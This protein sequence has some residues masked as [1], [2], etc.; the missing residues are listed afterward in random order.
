MHKNYFTL[1]ALA[2][3]FSSRLVDT[4]FLE[5]YSHQPDELI[6]SFLPEGA[7]A[8]PINIR[9]ITNVQRGCMFIAPYSNPPKRNVAHFFSSLQGCVISGVEMSAGDRIV[10]VRCD[11][12]ELKTIALAM[13]GKSGGNALLLNDQ[14]LIEESFKSPKQL[15]GTVFNDTAQPWRSFIESKD[16][17][18][19]TLHAFAGTIKAALSKAL[20]VLGGELADE[21]FFRAG[22]DS[23]TEAGMISDEQLETLFVMLQDILGEC[24]HHVHPQV[25]SH[26]KKIFFALIKMKHAGE[27]RTIPCESVSDGVRR[28]F[29]GSAK[30]EHVVDESGHV[31]ATLDRAIERTE[32]ALAGVNEDLDRDDEQELRKMGELLS[33]HAH[34]MAMGIPS[35]TLEGVDIALDK[36]LNA[37]QNAALYFERA[38]K[39]KAAV[40]QSQER[41]VK[42]KARLAQFQRMKT[43]LANAETP[44]QRKKLIEMSSKTFDAAERSDPAT[45]PKYPYRHFQLNDDCEVFVGKNAKQNDELTFRF[46]KQNDLWFHARGVEGSHTVLRWS[47][48]TDPPKEYI[49]RAAAI[50]AFYSK[51]KNSKYVPVAYTQRKYIHKPR[52]AKPGSV[53]VTREEV[54]MVEP[55]IPENTSED[56]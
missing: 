1:A 9:F 22:I 51:A 27:V 17:L 46:A 25:L 47:R 30:Q 36:K 32:R 54:V 21:I 23:K 37:I 16:H 29:A 41:L 33:A 53:A 34:E 56:I 55:R 45:P 38:K 12:G 5:A 11:T 15:T 10:Y 20:P 50:A 8:E 40:V 14:S 13:F 43:E 3:E 35:V 26:P 48:R 31:F 4:R 2:K 6:L 42:I 52:G 39:R 18:Q 28:W 7:N 49:L 44:E 19:Q 24:A